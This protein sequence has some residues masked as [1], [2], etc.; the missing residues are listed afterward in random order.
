MALL[1]LIALILL[2]AVG[3]ALGVKW[4]YE[5]FISGMSGKRRVL[6]AGIVCLL[7]V[8]A[9]Y[10]NVSALTGLKPA[11]VRLRE[12]LPTWQAHLLQT[13]AADGGCRTNFRDPDSPARTLLTR[14]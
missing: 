11:A 12:T 13:F 4:F 3:Y 6:L 14:S 8:G 5:S 1:G 10:A 9:V 2:I 7:G